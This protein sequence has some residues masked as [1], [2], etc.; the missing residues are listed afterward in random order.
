[1]ISVAILILY[2]DLQITHQQNGKYTTNLFNKKHRCLSHYL[3][4]LR[5]SQYFFDF[6]AESITRTLVMIIFSYNYTSYISVTTNIFYAQDGQTS[7]ISGD[8]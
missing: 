6:I 8:E 1:M 7:L 4:R 5:Q 3:K 2:N